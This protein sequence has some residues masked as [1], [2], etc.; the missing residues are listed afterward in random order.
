[1]N[2]KPAKK[3][4]VETMLPHPPCDTWLPTSSCRPFHEDMSSRVAALEAQKKGEE[5][6]VSCAWKSRDV[7]ETLLL[8]LHSSRV[9][10]SVVEAEATKACAQLVQLLAEVEGSRLRRCLSFEAVK[11]ALGSFVAC[12]QYASFIGKGKLISDVQLRGG[13]VGK[14]VDD[15]AFLF[16]T[17]RFCEE[18]EAYALGRA[19]ALDTASVAIAKDT[20]DQ[21]FAAFLQFDLKNGKL[22]RKFD[23][24]KYVVKSVE[25]KLY[26]LSTI[27]EVDVQAFHGERVDAAPFE[28]M[29]QRMVEFNERR[30]KVLRFA[31][32]VQKLS[33][34]AI[35]SV[36]RGD[37]TAA[38]KRLEE[39]EKGLK[40][41]K[42]LK[43]SCEEEDL[44]SYTAAFT[45]ALEE[46]AEAR[47]FV[48]WWEHRSILPLTELEPHATELGMKTYIGGLVDFTGELGRYAVQSATRRKID[49]VSVALK[50]MLLIEE[51]VLLMRPFTGDKF[52]KLK[53]LTTN[54]NKLKQLLFEQTV[55][56]KRSDTKELELPS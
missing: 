55:L 32:D 27:Q 36:H 6:L 48:H 9:D 15:E 40:E 49:E 4:K 37:L 33:K 29:A 2:G 51:E 24:L 38:K 35:F 31:R 8:K 13:G 47:L 7:L 52:L 26:S 28:A 23:G 43:K 11:A 17:L 14:S 18:L 41:A 22:R 12:V 56:R 53:Q 5:Q 3:R 34:V 46:Y 42:M 10:A 20:V 21:V 19:T 16:G 1:M 39:A 44:H 50:T 30:E 45:D 25:N 54:I